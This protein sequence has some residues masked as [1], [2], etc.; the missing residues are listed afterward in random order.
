VG[1]LLDEAKTMGFVNTTGIELNKVAAEVARKKGHAVYEKSVEGLALGCEKFDLITFNHVM[2]HVLDLGQFLHKIQDVLKP[3]G[4][5]YC[6]VPNYDSF[7]RR[8]LGKAWYGWGMPD[9]IWHF[10]VK[11]FC[12]VMQENGFAPKEVVQNS[13]Y[14]PYSKSL[15]KNTRACLAYSADRIGMGDQVYGIFVKK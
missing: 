4:V 11:T 1:Y 6:G 9:H 5:I 8:L 7:M 14:Y 3:D 12:A 2:E 10:D 13:L 15:R